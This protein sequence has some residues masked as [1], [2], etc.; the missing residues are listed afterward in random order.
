LCFYPGIRHREPCR[1]FSLSTFG[2]GRMGVHTTTVHGTCIFCLFSAHSRRAQPQPRSRRP[3]NLLLVYS[4]AKQAESERPKLRRRAT[5]GGGGGGGGRR[6]QVDG[7]KR[8]ASTKHGAKE[9]CSHHETKPLFCLFFCSPSLSHPLST[10]RLHASTG[11]GRESGYV[12]G[13]F[14]RSVG[15]LVGSIHFIWHLAFHPSF[16][17]FFSPVWR[18]REGGV[19]EGVAHMGIGYWVGRLRVLFLGGLTHRRQ[20]TTTASMGP[21]QPASQVLDLVWMP[22]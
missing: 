4:K 21:V 7:K 9:S 10:F 20:N 3:Q 8:C 18:R 15:W 17:F 1:V 11:P 19:R 6:I 16:F 12:F 13:R 22:V 14:G 5:R 2:L